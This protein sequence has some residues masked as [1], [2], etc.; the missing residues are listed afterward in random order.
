MRSSYLVSVW[1]LEFLEFGLL[2]Y[3]WTAWINCTY[4]IPSLSLYQ[5]S[6]G[7]GEC[8]FSS[9]EISPLLYDAMWYAGLSQIENVVTRELNEF[10]VDYEPI[11]FTTNK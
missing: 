11:C 9:T 2:A 7:I 5:I 3:V 8:Y 10:Y 6:R 1:S 4:T